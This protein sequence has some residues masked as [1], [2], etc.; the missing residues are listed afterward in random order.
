MI[1]FIFFNAFFLCF[2]IS[3]FAQSVSQD[4]SM[5]QVDLGVAMGKQTI[6]LNLEFVQK[7]GVALEG[8]WLLGYGLRL[9]W[10]RSFDD[11]EY[12]TASPK[13]RTGKQRPAS[14][15]SAEIPSQLDTF[16]T[17]KPGD[18]EFKFRII[19]RL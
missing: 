1:K 6:L 18:W 9:A 19:H 10:I 14:W 13:I 8:Q 7:F 15:W 16:I 3:L 17:E 12:H 4:S 11:L 5:K 2:N